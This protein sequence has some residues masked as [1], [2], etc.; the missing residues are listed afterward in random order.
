MKLVFI[1]TGLLCSIF[2]SAITKETAI[3]NI[4]K[5][6]PWEMK[7]HTMAGIGIHKSIPKGTT[8]EFLNDK[9]WKSS[10]PIEDFKIGRWSLENEGRTLSMDFGKTTRMFQIQKLTTENLRFR[11]NKFGAVYTY[12]WMAVK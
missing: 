1:I 2:H 11:L 4:L 9:T 8:I 3:E 5:S 10:E 6:H 12:E 7:I